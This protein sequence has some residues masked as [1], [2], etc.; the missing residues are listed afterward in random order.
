MIKFN[1]KKDG[2]HQVAL[3]DAKSPYYQYASNGR[4]MARGTCP[5]D[6]TNLSVFISTDK[7]P[8]GEKIRAATPSNKPK[9][10]KKSKKSKKGGECEGGKRSKRSGKKSGKKSGGKRSKRSAKK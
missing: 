10:S 1:C 4:V 7:V 9:K 5:K 3:K 2:D 6:G 8:S